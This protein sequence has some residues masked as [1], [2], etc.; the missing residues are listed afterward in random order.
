LIA[1]ALVAG[2]GV[3]IERIVIRPLWNR[4]STAF[5]MILATL[6]AQIVIERLTCSRSATSR[7]RCRCS[8]TCRRCASPASR[9]ATSS[10]GSS[11]ARRW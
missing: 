11:A 4:N 7:A 6:A 5:V 8:P 2:L 3:V 10:S 9:S 1:I